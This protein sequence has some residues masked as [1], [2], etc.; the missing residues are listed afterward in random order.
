MRALMILVTTTILVI[1]ALILIVD[2]KQNKPIEV[3]MLQVLYVVGATVLWAMSIWLSNW[4]HIWRYDPH[5]PY[6][7]YC[8]KCGTEQNY[9]A[10]EFTDGRSV[11][12]WETVLP[13][14]PCKHN[15]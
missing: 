8:K 9:Y 14:H 2:I 3:L 4:L 10:R 7:R 11:G 6:R 5:N 1:A 12:D 13:V 15:H